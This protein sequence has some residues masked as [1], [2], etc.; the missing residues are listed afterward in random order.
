[1]QMFN[2]KMA[3]RRAKIWGYLQANGSWL[4]AIGLINRSEIDICLSGLRWEDERYGAFDQT[5]H[6]YF[7]QL[8][9]QI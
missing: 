3:V 8:A 2:F 6:T 1:M 7:S 4:G 9:K 5:T